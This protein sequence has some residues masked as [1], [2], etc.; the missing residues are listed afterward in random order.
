M[1]PGDDSPNP[2]LEPS[3][4]RVQRVRLAGREAITHQSLEGLSPPGLGVHGLAS[5]LKRASRLPRR[6]ESS[7]GLRMPVSAHDWTGSHFHL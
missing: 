4:I 1:F 5:R 2:F 6:T 7:S 3:A